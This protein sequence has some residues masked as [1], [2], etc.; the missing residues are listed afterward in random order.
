[1]FFVN[2]LL[3]PIIGGIIALST[4]WLAIKMLFRPHKAKYIFGIRVPFTPGLIPKERANLA[5]KLATAISTR[6]LTP[7][8]LL[9]GLSNIASWPLPDIT[10]RQAIANFGMDVNMLAT[11]ATPVAQKL[12]PKL[13]M[14][15][16]NLTQTHPHLDEKLAQ[17][18]YKIIDENLGKIAGMFISKEKIYTS[19]KRNL[20]EYLENTENCAMVAQKLEESIKYAIENPGEIPIANN[21][22]GMNIRVGAQLLLKNQAAI[23]CITIATTYL[24]QNMPIQAMIEK[25]MNDFDVAEAEDIVLSVAGRELRMIIILGGFLG[26]IIGSIMVVI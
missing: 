16:Q 4:N 12:L 22:L 26:V 15:L 19:I 10:V 21:I 18:T 11:Q 7:D 24:A 13:A 9:D 14:A 6:L 23:K 8:V 2:Y 25:K 20:V 3:P 1:M 5:T 17:L